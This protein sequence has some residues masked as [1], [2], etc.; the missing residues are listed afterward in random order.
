MVWIIVG[1]IVVISG[2]LLVWLTRPLK[3]PR[4]PE[5][6]GA[7]DGPAVEAYD[8]TSGWL[9]FKLE[10]YIMMRELAREMPTGGTL[11]DIGCGP[12]YLAAEISR[13]YPSL[14]VTGLDNN[15]LM[16]EAARR[17][18]PAGR[19]AT[20]FVEGDAQQMPFAD[21]SLDYCVSSLSLHHWEDAAQVFREIQRVLKPGGRFIVLDLRRDCPIWMYLAFKIGQSLIAPEAVRRTNGAVGSFWAAY[22]PDELAAMLGRAGT[23]N[24][25]VKRRFGWMVAR[26]VKPPAVTSPA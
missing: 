20:A 2:A 11:V 12:G 18:W 23:G 19:Y 3:I 1:I 24:C 22:T 5:R 13:R 9:V 7:Q 17:N 16:I 25:R 4:E 26:G 6:E 14:K 21:D 8:R 15:Q 10:R